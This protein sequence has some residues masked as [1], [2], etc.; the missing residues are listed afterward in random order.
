MASNSALAR[1]ARTADRAAS[2]SPRR[3]AST[4]KAVPRN[5]VVGVGTGTS[6]KFERHRQRC[7]NRWSEGSEKRVARSNKDGQMKRDI[8]LD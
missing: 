2:K 1:S 6:L 3:I 8:G 7:L 5:E 4:I